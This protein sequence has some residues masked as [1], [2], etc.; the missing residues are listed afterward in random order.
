LSSIEEKIA[1]DIEK[2]GF[3][4]EATSGAAFT[5]GSWRVAHQMVFQDPEERKSRAIDVLAIKDL[6]PAPGPFKQ[7]TI[8]ALVECKKSNKPWVFYAPST[9]SLQ[10]KKRTISN[11]LK[12]A[13]RPKLDIRQSTLLEQSHYVTKEPLDRLAEAHYIAFNNPEGK[14]SGLDQIWTAINQATKATYFYFTELTKE[15]GKSGAST[16]LNVFYPI[17]VLEGTIFLYNPDQG[18]ETQI[19]QTQYVKVNHN[20]MTPDIDLEFFLIDVVTKSFLPT[21]IQ[22]LTAEANLLAL[23]HPSP[24][25]GF[26]AS[27]FR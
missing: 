6:T 16:D 4:V 9:D 20:F 5:K 26:R 17:V 23:T 22:W 21:Y 14:S 7:L 24:T 25:T 10:D 8:W 2:S 15:M 1:A 19:Q 3:P 11:Y 12:V 27:T 18:R 13:S